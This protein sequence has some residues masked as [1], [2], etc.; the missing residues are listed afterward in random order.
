VQA[1]NDAF[2]RWKKDRLNYDSCKQVLKLNKCKNDQMPY[3]PPTP[4]ELYPIYVGFDQIENK[5]KRAYFQ[6]MATSFNLPE[7]EVDDLRSIGSQI[8]EQSDTFKA[9]LNDLRIVRE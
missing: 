5:E 3:D 4:V 6:N 1:L 9:L 7:K 8:L 2:E